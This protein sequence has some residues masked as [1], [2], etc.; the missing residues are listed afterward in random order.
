[1]ELT[2]FL[3]ASLWIKIGLCIVCGVVVGTERQLHKKPIDIRTSV[4]ICL[5]TMTF[6]YLGALLDGNKDS[7]RVLG[8]VVTGIGFLGAGAII[9][10]LYAAGVPIDK[11]EEVTQDGSIK[12]AFKPIPI[13]FQI[14]KKGAKQFIPWRKKSCAGFYSGDSLARFINGEV[15]RLKA[16]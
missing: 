10:G 12:R 4:L 3:N 6:I 11:L 14:L 5:G 2:E 9:G 13:S 16:P 7:T 15:R 1:M 8:Q